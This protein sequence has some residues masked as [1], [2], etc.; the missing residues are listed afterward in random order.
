[1]W[2]LWPV[3]AVWKVDYGPQGMSKSKAQVKS[4]GIHGPNIAFLI[5]LA[6]MLLTAMTVS[7]SQLGF[8]LS[9][10]MNL[11][12]AGEVARSNAIAGLV[13]LPV[14]YWLGALSDR[15]GRQRFL[16]LS[17]LAAAAGAIFL[18]AAALL[19]HFWIVAILLMIAQGTN[20]SL[21]S[22]A[23]TD[24][25]I[26]EMLSHSLARLQSMNWVA[27][28]IGFTASGYLFE[29]YPPPTVFMAAAGLSILAAALAVLA[30]GKRRARVSAPGFAGQETL[31][32]IGASEC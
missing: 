2:I 18:S 22:A 32:A 7:I 3:M 6:S 8:S 9:M 4:P 29:V 27:G 21:A 11:F 10:K 12:S 13:T 17:F 24:M 15:F 1:M 23:V 5:L 28:I 26:P 30:L 14:S 31:P 25:V 19:W 16:V 20:L